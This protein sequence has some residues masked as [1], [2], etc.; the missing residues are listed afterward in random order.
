MDGRRPAPPS[1]PSPSSATPTSAASASAR[2]C[3]SWRSAAR[4]CSPASTP[5]SRRRAPRP[6]RRS[7]TRTS[8]AVP[9]GLVPGDGRRHRPPARRQ[10]HGG[11]RHAR[12]A[13]SRP[14]RAR[15][16]RRRG[17]ARRRPR[18]GRPDRPACSTCAAERGPEPPNASA[19]SATSA[20]IAA[21]AR[22]DRARRRSRRCRSCCAA[23]PGTGKELVARALHDRRPAAPGPFVARQPGRHPALARR[24]RAVRRRARGLHRRGPPAGGLLP[25]RPRRHALPRRD[26]RGAGRGAGDAAARPGD[27]RDLAGGQPGAAPGRRARR[28]RHRRDLEAARPRRRLPRAPAPPALRGYEIRLPPLR[29]RRDDIGR[30]LV[31]F[32]RQELAR[33]GRGAAGST[34]EAPG[35]RSAW[36][37]AGLVPGSPATPGPA[38]C[39]SSS[40]VARQLAIDGRGQ[41]RLPGTSRP[42]G[43]RRLLPGRATPARPLRAAPSGGLRRRAGRRRA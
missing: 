42:A 25:A 34:A 32:L 19:W 18:A 37:P 35:T 3:P 15:L 21:R 36:L 31:H 1:P 22:R 30:L 2:R 5:A 12:P 33:L 41:P 40:N 38:T 26:R 39:G 11:P 9:C 17:R 13:P 43:R 14:G 16:L 4:R 29:E 20:G 7:A 10:P 27:R 28:R 24:R 23:R 8:A 6:A